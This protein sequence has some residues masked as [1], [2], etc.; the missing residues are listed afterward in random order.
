VDAL[1]NGLDWS[2]DAALMYYV[3][4]ESYRVDVFDY[5]L[6]SGSISGRRPFVSVDRTDGTPDGLAV[7]DEGCVWLALWGGRAVRRYEPDGTL[8]RVVDVPAENVTACCF[9]GEDRRSLSI[10]TAAADG[11]VFVTDAGV[12]GPPARP[13]HVA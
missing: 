7:D 13:F 4:S 5:D 11:S 3:D 1:S 2:P 10:T 9:G 12:P 6:A 8:D